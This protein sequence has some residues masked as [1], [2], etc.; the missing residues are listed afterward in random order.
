MA[1]SSGSAKDACN[2]VTEMKPWCSAHLYNNHQKHGFSADNSDRVVGVIKGSK[3]GGTYESDPSSNVSA[4]GR[5]NGFISGAKWNTIRSSS[6]W[7]LE[8]FC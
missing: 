2:G 3:K 1:S 7:S 6:S 8:S 4:S 5:I